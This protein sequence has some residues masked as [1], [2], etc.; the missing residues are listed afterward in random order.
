LTI[1]DGIATQLPALV[2]AVATGIIVTRS[3]SDR[4]LSTEVFTQLA[5]IP[6]IPLI[7]AGI[8]C[9]LMVLP[10]MP[11]WPILI[12]V[13]ISLFTWYHLRRRGKD[14]AAMTVPDELTAQGHT[15]SKSFPVL[16]IMLGSKLGATWELQEAVIMDRVSSLRETHERAMGIGFPPLK[17]TGGSHLGDN[18]YEIRLFGT[19]YANGE[20]EADRVMAIK[21]EKVQKS[22]EGP[23]TTDPAF[24]LPAVW[25]EEGEAPNARDLHYT[26]IDPVTVFITHLGEVMQ[27]EAATY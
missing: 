8:L 9:L 21:S 25:I 16:E 12:L 17:L 2:I 27:S 15:I 23:Q 24:G 6:R 20:I 10:G 18:E 4:D 22:L 3:S 13:S 7:V 1:G 5:S 14:A 11:K 19:R 26:I